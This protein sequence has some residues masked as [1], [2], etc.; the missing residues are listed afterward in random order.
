[1]KNIAVFASGNGSNFQAIVNAVK[2]GNLKAH[3][4]LLACDNPKAYA[5]E[6]AKKAGIKTFLAERNNYASKR[7]FEDAIIK[8]LREEKIDLI[9]L[10]GF[11]RILSVDFIRQYKGRI[12]NVHP[13]LLP[14]FKGAHAIKDAFDYGVGV[15]GVTVHFVDEEVDH[16][17]IILQEAVKVNPRDTLESLEKKIHKAEH[18]IYPKVIQM[19]ICGKLRIECRRVRIG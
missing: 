10:A 7:E 16:G 19:Y 11:M 6:R 15:T 3:L 13:A 12:L 14:S 17:P 1:M 8:R 4:K 9:V 2:K 5:F 18:R